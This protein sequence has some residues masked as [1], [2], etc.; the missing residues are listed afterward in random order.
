[1]WLILS[2]PV[3]STKTV[4]AGGRNPTPTCTYPCCTDDHLP[5][6]LHAIHG[7]YTADSNGPVTN[8]GVDF[9]D[10]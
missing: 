7:P 1:M 3:K 10:Y 8:L 9:H 2:L 5:R 4:T 6:H